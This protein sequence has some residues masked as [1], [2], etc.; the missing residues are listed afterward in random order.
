MTTSLSDAQEIDNLLGDTTYDSIKY[1]AAD[2]GWLSDI[3]NG[4]YQDR[5]I[6]STTVLKQQLVDYNSAFITVPLTISRAQL[7][8]ADATAGALKQAAVGPANSGLTSAADY[9]STQAAA[10]TAPSY[11]G[12]YMKGPQAN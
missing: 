4:S 10:S 9:V 8:P 2:W 5:V 7:V 3:N 11:L 6:F 1:N 12:G